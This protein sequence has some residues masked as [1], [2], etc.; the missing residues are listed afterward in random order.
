MLKALGRL[1]F[2]FAALV[3]GYVLGDSYIGRLPNYAGYFVTKVD[4][5]VRAPIPERPR[6]AAFIVIDGLRREAA[7]RMNV[8]KALRARGQCRTS[9]QGSYTVSRPMYAVLSTGLE[10]DRTG[11]RNND[12]TRPLP[13]ESIWEIA[14]AAKMKVAGS[15]HLPWFREL[16]PDGFDTFDVGATHASNVF[17]QTELAAVNVFHPLYVDEA[18]HHYGGASQEYADAAAR[19]DKEAST[20]VARLDLARDLVFF[21][22]DHGHTDS[23]GHGGAQPVIANV[24]FC[25]AGLHVNKT[26]DASVI[27]ARVI[28]PALSVLLGVHFPSNMRAGEDD[29]DALWSVVSFSEKDATYVADRKAAVE[30]FRAA[31]RDTLAAWLHVPPD[32][33][34]WSQLYAGERRGQELRALVVVVVTM[35]AFLVW[36][37]RRPRAEVMFCVGWIAGT[38]LLTWAVHR[39]VLGGFD[40]TVINTRAYFLPRAFAIALGAGTLASAIHVVMRRDP[41]RWFGDQR[42]LVGL[43]IVLNLGHIVAYG[44]PLGFPLPPTAGRY[45]PFFSAIALASNSAILVVSI[46]FASRRSKRP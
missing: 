13:V 36:G 23:G 41:V 39:V 19:A 26:D 30:H 27:D 2:A 1:A 15:S 32:A 6:H 28:A 35:L 7:E 20:L 45:F 3:L 33:A 44:W 37:R 29:L 5:E 18:G 16:F 21:T 43:W 31:N 12:E 10:V 22:A 42:L 40:Y 8:V 9:D 4:D 11:A 24:L 34:T 38:L 14:R 46:A 25:A 17:A